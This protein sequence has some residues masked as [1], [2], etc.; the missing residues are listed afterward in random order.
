MLWLHHPGDPTGTALCGQLAGRKVADLQTPL[1]N[2]IHK[3]TSIDIKIHIY[4]YV[5]P[6]AVTPCSA[7]A[8]QQRGAEPGRCSAACAGSLLLLSL[9]GEGRVLAL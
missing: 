2:Q 5:L 8:A 1:P 9:G 7:G 4:S 6:P 3:D